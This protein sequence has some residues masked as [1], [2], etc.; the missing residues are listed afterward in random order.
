M[1]EGLKMF[2]VSPHA[3]CF[4]PYLVIQALQHTRAISCPLL[5]H[6][7]MTCMSITGSQ[8]YTCPCYL[9]SNSSGASVN[10]QIISID[11][12]ETG[13]YDQYGHTTMLVTLTQH[14]VP[15]DSCQDVAEM[16]PA[17]QSLHPILQW[18]CFHPCMPWQTSLLQ[19]YD[20]V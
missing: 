20:P 4:E 9:Q 18:C 16:M 3:W 7:C 17:C 19:L 11:S 6:L 12:H 14:M 5:M 13:L 2:K 8:S 1:R 15:L 10:V